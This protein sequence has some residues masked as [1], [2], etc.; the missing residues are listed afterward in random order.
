MMTAGKAKSAS[1]HTASWC[2][3]GLL[4]SA[5]FT[6]SVGRILCGWIAAGVRLDK[7]KV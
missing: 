6:N 2:R 5:M 1:K 7:T 3:D 4:G